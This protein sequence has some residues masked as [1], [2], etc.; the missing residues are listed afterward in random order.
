MGNIND[1]KVPVNIGETLYFALYDTD[2]AI[3]FVG[4][5]LFSMLKLFLIN[6]FELDSYSHIDTLERQSITGL[7]LRNGEEN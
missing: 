1:T 5:C 7:E 6:Y 4:I 3:I 2:F